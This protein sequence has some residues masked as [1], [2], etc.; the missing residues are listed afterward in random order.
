MV[1]QTFLAEGWRI[2]L[3]WGLFAG[4]VVTGIWNLCEIRDAVGVR[5]I[6]GLVAGLSQLGIV[7]VLAWGLAHRKRPIIELSGDDVRYRSI[8][9][10]GEGKRVRLEDIKNVSL[11]GT[12]LVLT[13]SGGKRLRLWLGD[14]SQR[15]RE[16]VR[17]AIEERI[18]V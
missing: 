9:W 3:A 15:S 4:L 6:L 10:F 8:Y 12:R 13:T 7:G 18:R 16:A 17:S 14:L 11:K 2:K 5:W 1:E